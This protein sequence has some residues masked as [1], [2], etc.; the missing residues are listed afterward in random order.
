VHRDLKP[1]N[2]L[3]FSNSHGGL[4]CKVAD[5]DLAV[6]KG[7]T[8][9]LVSWVCGTCCGMFVWFQKLCQ[10]CMQAGTPGY[11]PPDHPATAPLMRHSIISPAMGSSSTIT[12]WAP[13]WPPLS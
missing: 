1:A 7:T 11:R 13:A 9:G 6:E 12:A 3:V 4:K 8:T 10:W 2:L 5:Y